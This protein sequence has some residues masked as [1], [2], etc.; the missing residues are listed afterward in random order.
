M[1]LQHDGGREE[2]RIIVEAEDSPERLLLETI[3]NKERGFQKPQ[4]TR[5]VRRNCRTAAGS[6]SVLHR[7][8]KWSIGSFNSRFQKPCKHGL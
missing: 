1:I 5:S 6:S 4:G 3:I 2:P 7:L 8:L